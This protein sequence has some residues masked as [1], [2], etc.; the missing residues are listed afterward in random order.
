MQ[1]SL[2][3]FSEEGGEEVGDCNFTLVAPAHAGATAGMNIRGWL[4]TIQEQ[5]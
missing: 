5:T 1:M 2:S 3:D 4:L